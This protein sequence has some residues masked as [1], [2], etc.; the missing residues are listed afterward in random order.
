[1]Q[2]TSQAYKKEQLQEYRQQSYVYVYL[3][4]VSR[5]AQENAYVSSDL[6]PISDTSQILAEPNFEG[7]YGMMEQNFYR[8]DGSMIFT[9]TDLSLVALYQGAIG[10]DILDGITFEFNGYSALEIKGLTINFGDYYPTRFQVTN[11]NDTYTYDNSSSQFVCED[12]FHDT[13]QIVIT[14]LTMVGGQ[15]RMRILSIMFGVGL[16]FDNTQLISTS[17]KNSVSHISESLPS[18]S[19]DFRINNRSKRFSQDDPNSF[20]HFLQ[21]QQDVE[22]VYARDV[23]T[24]YDEWG[25]PTGMQK[26][27]ID[28]GV[29]KLK[30][31]SSNDSEASFSAVGYLD[32]EQGTYYKGKYYPNG[33][34]VYDEALRILTDAGIENYRLDT[35]LHNL[36]L[37]N[38]V[39]TD[40]HKACLQLLANYARCI[41]YEDRQGRVVIESSFVPE[42]TAVTSTDADESSNVEWIVT[43]DHD[44][45]MFSY[46]STELDYTWA[47]SVMRIKPRT[48][49]NAGYVSNVVADPIGYFSDVVPINTE[50]DSTLSPYQGTILATTQGGVR[51]TP[52]ITITF[53]AQWTFFNLGI[54]FAYSAPK[55]IIINAY[56]DN[57]LVSSETHT[58]DEYFDLNAVFEQE[59]REIDQ[60]TIQFVRTHPGQRIHVNHIKFGDVTDYTV[61]Y[62]DMVNTPV[63]ASLD[64]VKEIDFHYYT[65]DPS[66]DQTSLVKTNVSAGNNTITFKDA[67]TN[68]SVAWVDANATGT[69]TIVESGAYYC[70]VNS[71]ADGQIDVQGNKYVISDNI[72]RHSVNETG[73]TKTVQ[74]ELVSTLDQAVL[75]A[76][77]LAEYFAADT[78]YD[79]TYRGE[80]ALDC[81][82]LIY[83][84]NKYVKNNLVRVVEE[85]LNTSVGM[86][87]NCKIKGRRVSYEGGA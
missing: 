1:M 72:Y 45:E 59:F 10:E 13:A 58:A 20:I 28:G 41:L 7:Y 35:Y 87:M 34:T 84:E 71:T 55:E 67:A 48:G 62:R 2:F 83:V 44:D 16:T 47:D 3:G 24:G 73:V 69:L 23:P 38:P 75:D 17:R 19:F 43:T 15:Q 40:T 51:F 56:A 4:V 54:E 85:Q 74:N 29:V 31:W 57:T 5:E 21:E 60:V 18:K 22:Y 78:E 14:P 53:E 39:P 65:Y 49:G 33:T 61:R 81:D 30:T 12:V 42:I 63:A 26:Y 86:D 52:S 64:K 8:V 25:Y 36:A 82:D 50:D 70:V 68:Y 9:P 46:Q 11:G 37:Y 80:P 32:Y 79:I 76:A 27:Y 6:L 66:A 77:W